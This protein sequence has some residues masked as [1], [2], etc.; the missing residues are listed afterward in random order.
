MKEMPL[1]SIIVPV[2]NSEKYLAKCIDSLI[3][4]TLSEIEIIM[5]NDGS[6]DNSREICSKYEMK[7]DRIVVIDN[8]HVGPS[9][10][11][12]IGLSQ[13][14]G[15]YIMFVDSDDWIKLEACEFLY[16]KAEVMKCDYIFCSYVNETNKAS[17]RKELFPDKEIVYSSSDDLKTLLLKVIGPYGDTEKVP[18]KVNALLPIWARFFRASIIK[19]NN[20]KFIDLNIIPSE[21]QLFNFEFLSY[22]K[23]AAYVNR[24]FYHYRCDNSNTVIKEYREDLLGKWVAWRKIVLSYP[25]GHEFGRDFINTVNN[26]ICFSII[27][28]GINAIRAN[29]S[30]KAVK[31]IKKFLKHDMFVNAF[32]AFDTKG[33][34]QHWRIYFF[35]AKHGFVKSFYYGTKTMYDTIYKTKV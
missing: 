17:E 29:D 32:K 12:N 11:R 14:S 23:K 8:P 10:A 3:C 2:Y 31:E 7:D 4:Q 24:G 30:R 6:T 18:S 5:V 15:K 20:I 25:K 33:F 26:R 27:P 21:T 35:C 19:E 13:V 1:V 16:N 22:V 9:G 28:L 34:S